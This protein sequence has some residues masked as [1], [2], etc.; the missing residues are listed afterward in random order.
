MEETLRV[1]PPRNDEEVRRFRALASQALLFELPPDSPWPKGADRE[2]L[3]LA[4]KGDVVVGGY[5]AWP[6]GQ[7]FGGRSVPMAAVR[8]VAVA[9]EHRGQGVARAMMLRAL[10]D[11]RASGLAISTLYPATQGLYRRFGWEAAGHRLLWRVPLA[12][13]PPGERPT[14]V[15]ELSADDVPT[16][17]RLHDERA[18]RQNG[19]LDRNAFLWERLVAPPSGERRYVYAFEDD[20]GPQG[21]VV[22]GQRRDALAHKGE[23]WVHDHVA[24]TADAARHVRSFLADHRSMVD[25]LVLWG[26][27]AEPLLLPL[28]P[29]EFPVQT[30]LRWM[31]RIVDVIAALEERGYAPG[32]RGELHLDVVDP[33]LPHNH[34]RFVLSVEEGRGRVHPGGSGALRVQARG[35]SSLYASYLSAWELSA[36]GLVDG[37]DEVLRTATSFFAGPQPWMPELF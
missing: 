1:G 33:V 15:R 9:P 17:R 31:V 37:D 3:K 22:L 11:A 8:A 10:H 21:Y 34:G 30:W 26:A 14:R 35:L 28:E 23:L 4:K 13:L 5:V 25:T 24:L 2:H 16:L 29:Q 7:F 27:P 32:L 18:R 6:L 19:Q 12:A 20:D 36:A